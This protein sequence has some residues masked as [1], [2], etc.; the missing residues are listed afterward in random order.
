LNNGESIVLRLLEAELSKSSL[1]DLGFTPDLAE[2]LQQQVSQQ[3]GLILVT[4]PTGS[5]KTTTLYSLLSY[6]NRPELKIISIEDPVELSIPGINQIQ[7]D[8]QHGLSFAD[9]LRS[10][11]RQDPDIIMVGEI[12]DKETAQMAAQAALTGHLVL[13]TLHTSSAPAA[14]TRLQNLGLPNYLISATLS[15]VLAQRLLRRICEECSGASADVISA[16]CQSC[17]AS[18]FI[19]RTSVAE[20]LPFGEIKGLN[21]GANNIEEELQKNLLNGVSLNA[22]GINKVDQG[23]TNNTEL[24]RVLGFSANP[25]Q[26]D[27]A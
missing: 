4:G 5:G 27:P 6:L 22:D 1:S 8:E 2:K 12:R 19:G 10:V 16:T 13:S 15:G 3:Q 7:V 24:T 11:L 20:Y 21:L 26:L 18:G 9:A 14:V 17:D 25:K 23:L